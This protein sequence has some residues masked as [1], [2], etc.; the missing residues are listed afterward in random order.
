MDLCIYALW[1]GIFPDAQYAV[2]HGD[3]Y[4]M[5]SLGTTLAYMCMLIQLLLLLLL[6]LL[7]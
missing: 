6:L 1:Y 4:C 3:R 7:L 5:S 2:M